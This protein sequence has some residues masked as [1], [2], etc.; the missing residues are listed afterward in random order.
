[1]KSYIKTVEIWK[2]AVR[3]FISDSFVPMSL[4]CK[5]YIFKFAEYC[6]VIIQL[7]WMIVEYYRPLVSLHGINVNF[8]M[9]FVLITFQSTTSQRT[10]SFPPMNSNQRRLV[11]ELAVFYNCASRSYDKEPKRNTVVTATKWVPYA[12]A[13]SGK[14]GG[15]A[16]ENVG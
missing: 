9:T 2:R 8:K 4:N 10:H 12:V 6:N 5:N 11:H 3:K 7:R 16:H 13:W 14:G 15:G 1:M